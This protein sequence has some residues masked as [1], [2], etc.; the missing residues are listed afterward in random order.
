MPALA[1]DFK[2]RGE[3]APLVPTLSRGS[4][5][6]AAVP[7]HHPAQLPAPLAQPPRPADLKLD[8]TRD[9]LLT[10][11]G[12]ATLSDRYLLAGESVQDMF[13]CVACAF[14]DDS[15]QARRRS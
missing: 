8:R 11:F 15:A 9:D 2:E 4:P 12:K 6:V 7:Q 3:L 13:A 10:A 14:R 1:F 5:R